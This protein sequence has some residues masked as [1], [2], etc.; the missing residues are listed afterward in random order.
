M[1]SN[2]KDGEGA[3]LVA[4]VRTEIDS[5]V[6]FINLDAP[7]TNLL[8]QPVRAALL[9]ALE[10][11][12]GNDTVQGV[13]LA[14]SAALFSAGVD[15]REVEGAGEAAPRLGDICTT[16]E[17]FPKPVVAALTGMALGAGL[18]LAL[19]AHARVAD[20]ALRIGFPDL[21][22]GL[23]P[24]A[25]GTQRLPRLIGAGHALS[26]LLTSRL[27][28][29]KA[30]IAE[31]LFD[32]F[33]ENAVT[34]AARM[35]REIAPRKTSER[36]EG[37]ADAKA[38]QKAVKEA[39]ESATVKALGQAAERL[40]DCIEASQL[41]PI[42]S[43][44]AFEAAAS[45]DCAA[46][47]MSRALIHMHFAERRSQN[48]PELVGH[49]PKAPKAIGVVGGGPA[50]A[51]IAVAA[52]LHGVKVV[53]FE[54]TEEAAKAA[55]ARIDETVRS[56]AQQRAVAPAQAGALM[57]GLQQTT[58]LAGLAACGFV[59]EAVAENPET[60]RQVFA[61]LGAAT[62]PG[63]VLATS[64]LIQSLTP[65]GEA[66]GRP[67]DVIALH[68]H[69][70]AY[71]HRL[72]EIVLA[73][74]TA[75]ETLA[76]A[77]GFAQ[78][79]KK[80]PVRA[81]GGGCGIGERVQAALRDCMTGLVVQG[82]APATI[83]AA[84]LDYG[85][86]HAPLAA[87]DR[88]GLELCLTRGALLAR[89]GGRVA[90]SS[91]DVLRTLI[92]AGRR[93]AS[94]GVGFFI[95]QNEQAV[96]D[97]KIADVLPAPSQMAQRMTAADIVARCVAAMA[98]EGARILREGIALRPSDIDTVMVLGYGFPRE[99]GGPM[100]AA[101]MLGVFETGLLLKRLTEEDQTLYAP[102]PGFAALAREGESFDALNKLGKNRRKIPG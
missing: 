56:V 17:D 88:M 87:M 78:V 33:S 39:R 29:A 32:A 27:H 49:E 67:A 51:G 11:A 65:L 58:D 14:G 41:L 44:L 40:V 72:A 98:N 21:S 37:F 36:I 68:L 77:V 54:R 34:E 61:A 38:F 8:T 75:P 50:A 85:F 45:E 55:R 52:L 13:V 59:I 7:P 4:G 84:L 48:M 101:D 80:F 5:G 1:Q 71:S 95:W 83:D 23:L 69:G 70:P 96:D 62:G 99:R 2:G 57:A 63:T 90:R 19:A 86:I 3:E 73:R 102:D 18:E 26:L 76:K 43:G 25:G 100:K 9:K 10:T 79:L 60:K 94:S 12:R 92:R 97:P 91:L 66:A 28:S 15:V 6:A 30:E 31:G 46:S 64:S 93:G 16:I 22:F 20:P 35:A 47:D 81:A 89:D 74:E 42:E 82:V 53:Q 24:G